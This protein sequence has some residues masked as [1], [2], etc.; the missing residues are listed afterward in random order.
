MDMSHHVELPSLE[1]LW[2]SE[3]ERPVRTFDPSRIQSLPVAVKRFL[4]HAIE[5]GAPLYQAIRLRMRGE[6]KLGR[7][8]PFEAE[9][10]IRWG[11][12]M[13][14]RAKAKLGPLSIKGQDSIVDGV[15]EMRWRLAG[16][17]PVMS[18]DGPD[19]SRSAAGRLELEA[20]LL[21]SVLLDD[22]VRWRPSED[23]HIAQAHVHVPGDEGLITLDVDDAGHLRSASIPRWGNPEGGGFHEV[24]FGVHLRGQVRAAGYAI[25]SEI[26]AGWYFGTPRFESEG[27]FFRGEILSFELR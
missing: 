5:P 2:A 10:V 27:E 4:G 20:T 8:R 11:R 12:G 7:W 13:V 17:I 19:I 26:R 22:D 14:W 1:E 23:D 21:P 24:P 16:I 25:A 18:A 3:P 15:G 6:I 9:Q